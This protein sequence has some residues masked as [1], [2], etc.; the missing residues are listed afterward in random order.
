MANLK[1][2]IQFIKGVGPKIATLLATRQ[3]VTIEDLLRFLPRR[4][5]QRSQ[6]AL[7]SLCA[8]MA[9]TVCGKVTSANFIRFG[10]GAQA[11]IA[12]GSGSV[13]LKW[14]F[15]PGGKA[16]LRRYTQGRYVRASGKVTEFSG[17]LQMVH[18]EVQVSDEPFLLELCSQEEIVPIYSEIDGLTPTQLR[19]LLD[20]V[21]PLAEQFSEFFPESLLSKRKLASLPVAIKHLHRPIPQALQ[22]LEVGKTSWQRRLV[23]EELLLLQLGLLRRKQRT[24]AVPG[25]RLELAQSLLQAAPSFIPFQLT[26]AQQRVLGEIENDLRSDWPMHRLLQ[27]DVGSGKTAV[28]M[29]AVYAA[30]QAGGQAAL[31]AP[32]ELLAEQHARTALQ[33]F[34]PLGLRVGLL[35]GSLTAAERRCLLSDLAS[36]ILHMVIGTHALIQDDVQYKA[37]NL[38]VIDEQHRFGVL[39]RGRILELG[40]QGLGAMPHT[41]VMT[42]TPIPRTLA[43][44]VYGD[45]DV[46]VLDEL[47]P[48]RTPITTRVF[49]EAQRA[50]AY[51]QIKAALQR[52]RQA[53]VVFPLIE[54]SDKEG[55]EHLRS[56][57]A[58]FEEM[59]QSILSDFR[60]G[61][62]HGRMHSDDK[63]N[64]MRAFNEHRIDVLVATTVIE[65]GIDVG[66]ATV[67][68]VENAERFGLSQLHQLRGRVG[69]SAHQSE[70]YLLASKICSKEA[71]QRLLVMQMFQDGFKVAEEDLQIRGP[72]DFVGTRQSGL[73]MLMFADLIRD[74]KLLLAAREDAA[75]LLSADPDLCAPENLRLKQL[76]QHM[77]QEKWVTILS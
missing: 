26:Q 19:R 13:T 23:Y 56:A 14:F 64:M 50:L 61:L 7:G 46:S 11:I 34:T 31:M 65:V 69:R 2:P 73:P 12:D 41:L 16:F 30:I 38:V 15:S 4:Y 43:L 32:T 25:K 10:R 39:Q 48:G 58:A 62:L 36:G 60:I 77:W 17:R 74:Q 54:E 3:I 66:N 5:E 49:R 63:D 42:A 18:P 33:W 76:L 8:G 57:T 29:L 28:A 68:V 40:Q 21:L 72:G 51:K 44:T 37:L 67:M 22:A 59:Q 70:C 9:A 53:Y 27:G 1:D 75:E 35:T 6:Q 52:G 45:L 24:Q 47:P 55:F 20:A 71:Y